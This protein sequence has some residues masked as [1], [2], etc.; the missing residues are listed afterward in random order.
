MNQKS[1]QAANK[2]SAI[3][4]FAIIGIVLLIS[5]VGGWWFYQSS[6][7]SPNKASANRTANSAT[8][9]RT[10]Q[11]PANAPLGAQPPNMLGS[12]SAA[13]TIEEFADFQCGSC[14]L[15]HPKLQEIKS[16]YGSRIK[17][18]YRNYPLTTIHQKSYDAAVAAEAAGQQGKFWDMQN[19]LFSNQQTWVAASD[20]RGLFEQYAQKI[21][22]DVPKFQNDLA[23]MTTKTRVDADIQRG[24]ALN[25]SSTPTVYI[26][27]VSIPYEQLNVEPLRRIIDA[28]LQKAGTQNQAT[29]TSAPTGSGISQP[30][31]TAVANSAGK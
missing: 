31:N 17:F 8:A 13:V 27:G 12:P 28:E 10:P 25:V 18:I 15:A 4:P 7:T 26:N 24:R 9:Q 1:K 14:A 29:Q 2:N 20:H 11:I 22:L 6:K 30:A 3:L 16:I 19:Q 5:I 23:A 21:G